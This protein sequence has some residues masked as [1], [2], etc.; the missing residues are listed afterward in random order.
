M[1]QRFLSFKENI[2]FSYLEVVEA[3]DALSPTRS[4]SLSLRLSPVRTAVICVV[5][6][7]LRLSCSPYRL[8]GCQ[9]APLDHQEHIN[10]SAQLLRQ[11]P[12][13]ISWLAGW[14]VGWL[15]GWLA[16]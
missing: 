5:G 4:A 6:Y 8:P 7:F 9:S 16:G 11:T 10:R 14:L 13:H 15:V 2:S 3:V 12:T 1:F